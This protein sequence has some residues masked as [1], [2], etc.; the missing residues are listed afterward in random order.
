MGR[1]RRSTVSPSAFSRLAG[2]AAARA[3]IGDGEI[4]AALTGRG[5]AV[6][7]EPDDA[8]VALLRARPRRCW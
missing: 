3:A 8:L 1:P 6:A 7:E 4:D 5:L 2:P